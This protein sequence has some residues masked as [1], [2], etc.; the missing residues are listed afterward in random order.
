MNFIELKKEIDERNIV[1]MTF[2]SVDGE[3]SFK[4]DRNG[5]IQNLNVSDMLETEFN[6]S[7][8]DV[9]RKYIKYETD[10]KAFMESMKFLEKGTLDDLN[11]VIRENDGYVFYEEE[12]DFNLLSKEDAKRFNK[13]RYGV[14]LGFDCYHKYIETV[15]INELDNTVKNKDIVAEKIKSFI[16]D[17]DYINKCFDAENLVEMVNVSHQ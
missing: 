3:S 9:K 7:F 14:N 1:N 4:V 2:V 17:S 11:K 13:F 15:I 10:Y 6:V 5:V 12:K 16:E 8:N